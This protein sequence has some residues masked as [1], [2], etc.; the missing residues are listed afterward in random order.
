MVYTPCCVYDQSPISIQPLIHE[1]RKFNFIAAKTLR[2]DNIVQHFFHPKNYEFYCQT[3]ASAIFTSKK[4]N[5]MFSL[6]VSM[7][8]NLTIEC[9]TEWE[10][11]PRRC[12]DR[13]KK[14]SD[15]MGL[16]RKI[17]LHFAIKR[18]PKLQ[19]EGENFQHLFSPIFSHDR[20]SFFHIPSKFH[21]LL[22]NRQVWHSWTNLNFGMYFPSKDTI[23][24]GKIAEPA[25][26][27]NEKISSSN[28]RLVFFLR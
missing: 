21:Q 6:N 1:D 16:F 27:S 17:G 7:L 15:R 4:K 22:V 11:L 12:F 2:D 19:I 25:S 13:N 24:R 26:R 8:S 18:I 14:V 3:A 10:I 28:F 5:V 9:L 23:D 20:W